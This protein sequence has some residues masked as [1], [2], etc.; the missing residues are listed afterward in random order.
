[1]EM[2]H[3]KTFTEVVKQGGFGK[4]AKSQN[5]AQSTITLQIQELERVLGIT[6]F[7]RNG[8]SVKLTELGSLCFE[9]ADSL[10]AQA[11]ELRQSMRELA[12]AEKGRVTIGV[13]E[14]TAGIR[15]PGI[16]AQF[17]ENWPRVET[18]ISSGNSRHMSGRVLSGEFDFAIC[19]QSLV[20][21]DLSF[22]KLF[23]ER[24][25]LFMADNHPLM[26]RPYIETKDL[27][28]YR[29]LLAERTCPYRELFEIELT[30]MTGQQPVIV[31]IGSFEGLR[32]A[33]E[34]GLGVAMLPE[35]LCQ[36]NPGQG[37][38]RHARDMSINVPIGL[39]RKSEN[40][41]LRVEVQAL[42]HKV[43]AELTAPD[44]LVSLSELSALRA[45]AR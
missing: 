43:K 10:L 29:L 2:R 8:R 24:M 22:E 31:E 1:M 6:L 4:A 3:L 9:K 26:D 21:G 40:R 7:E 15:M 42:L 27:V 34:L 35:I 37:A 38:I 18:T 25:C 17:C 23:D 13:I 28:K 44:N 11:N 45:Q 16:I 19:A 30:E 41:E 5:L 36:E 39:I 32:Q 33:A 20:H 14:P 12:S